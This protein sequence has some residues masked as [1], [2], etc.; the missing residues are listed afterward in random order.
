MPVRNGA[1]VGSVIDDDVNKYGQ[2]RTAKETR[3]KNVYVNWIIKV[4]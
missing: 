2:A 1:I 3:P 4:K